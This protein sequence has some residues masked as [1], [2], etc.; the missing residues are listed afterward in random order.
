MDNNVYFLSDN[1][2]HVFSS[3]RSCNRY[4]V[5][6]SYVEV[7]DSPEMCHLQEPVHLRAVIG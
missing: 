7:T 4:V 1:A 2:P 5:S 3:S 6:Y